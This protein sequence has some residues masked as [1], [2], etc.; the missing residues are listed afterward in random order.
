[1]VLGEGHGMRGISVAA[2]LQRV[3]VRSRAVLTTCVYGL[4]AGVA[5][6]VF[7][8][9]M[10]WLYRL[11]LVR[12]AAQSKLTFLLGSLGVVVASSLWGRPFPSSLKESTS[13][14]RSQGYAAAA[15]LTRGSTTNLAW[16]DRFFMA[17]SASAL[18]TEPADSIMVGS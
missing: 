7:Q 5:T 18:L 10:N 13:D 2:L 3:P 8:L 16:E 15:T 14:R 6:V 4:A 9:G 17:S 1:M 11:G 12:L